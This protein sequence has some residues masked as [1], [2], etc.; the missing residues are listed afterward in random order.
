[1]LHSP[2]VVSLLLLVVSHASGQLDLPPLREDRYDPNDGRRLPPLTRVEDRYE[3]DDGRRLPQDNGYDRDEG[4]RYGGNPQDDRYDRFENRRP[5]QPPRDDG[6]EGHPDRRPPPVDLANLLAGLDFVGAQRCSDNVAAQWNYETNVN[7]VTQL[8]ALQAQRLYADF[9]F[10]AWLQ[11]S[12]IDPN[13]VRDATLRRRLRYLSAVGPAALPPDQLDRYNRVINDMLSIY[14]SATICA[15]KEPL[16]CGLRLFP[17]IQQIMARSKDWDELQWVWTE[18]RRRS[19]SQIKELYQQLVDLNNEAARLNNFTDAADY[20]QFP[21]ETFDFEQEI[22]E[23]W[24]EI[25]PLY[26][27]LHAYIRKRLRDI[28][29][30][31]KISGHAPLPS[32]V[33]GNIWA[34]SWTNILDMTMPYPGKNYL[35]VTHEMQA[36]GYTP[37]DMFRVG[38]DFFLSM[39]L[40][41]LPPEFW[42][43]SELIDPGNRPFICQASAWDFCNRIDYRIKMCTKVTMKDLITVHHEMAHVHYFLRYNHLP[44]EFRDGANP[45]FHEAVGEAVALSVATPKHLQMLGLAN[46]FVDERAAD[47]NYLF[48]L[49]MEKLVLLPYSIALDKWRYDVFR[50]KIGRNEFNCHWHRLKEAYAGTKPP[51]LRSEDDFDPGSKYHVPANIPY[52]RNFVSGVLQFQLYRALCRAAG[53]RSF[54][55]PRKPLH[56]CDFYRSPEAGAILGKLMER[57]ASR[58][59]QDVLIEA[60]GEARL[61]ASALREYFRPLEDWLRAENF[62]TNELVGWTYDGDYCKLSIETAGLEVYGNGYYFNSAAPAYLGATLVTTIILASTLSFL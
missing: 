35:D 58:P 38:E 27:E 37:I 60:T 19:G 47:I 62:R 26:E 30:P 4:R 3:P 51:V 41:A 55:D 2:V 40:S 45:G 21:Y 56:R 48:S 6:Y 22:D 14:N 33:L 31:E 11:V 46:K 8:Q 28:Y 9:Q 7:E 18:W 36:R 17:E 43:G 61:N 54:D 42:A 1:M 24:A 15:Y 39:N 10:Q 29:G 23:V 13:S 32:H 50:G 16:R 34:Q 53:Q 44:R 12:Q 52:I 25:K 5:T 20:W 57:G 49:A 59:W